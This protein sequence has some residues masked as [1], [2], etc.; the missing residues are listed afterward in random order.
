M[1]FVLAYLWWKLVSTHHFLMCLSA[2]M[3]EEILLLKVEKNPV[4][5]FFSGSLA[6]ANQRYSQCSSQ[7]WRNY[8]KWRVEGH[9]NSD[10]WR[11]IFPTRC[12]WIY[13]AGG[14]VWSRVR[15]RVVWRN[16]WDAQDVTVHSWIC[17]A[18]ISNGLQFEVSIVSLQIVGHLLLHNLEATQTQTHTE[19]LLLAVWSM[20]GVLWH[21]L[22]HADWEGAGFNRCFSF[23]A[24]ETVWMHRSPLAV[25]NLF[26]S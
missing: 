22:L 2:W 9:N 12:V 13:A 3:Q 23:M 19:P 24:R 21:M 11:G 6:S 8:C 17:F 4:L 18:T 1:N 14:L 16:Q 15:S 5:F 20:C 7:L 25:A 10:K 26:V